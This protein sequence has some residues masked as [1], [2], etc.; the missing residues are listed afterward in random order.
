MENHNKLQIVNDINCIATFLAKR[1]L[2]ELDAKELL[3]KFGVPQVDMLIILGN[4]IPYTAQV[5]AIA[6]KNGLASGIMI[7]GGVGHSTKGIFG[8]Y[9]SVKIRA[10]YIVG[11][12]PTE[13]DLANHS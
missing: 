4:S 6:Y 9:Q 7:V 2:G 5:G 10:H 13:Q 12:I 8:A 1:D 3:S 11:G